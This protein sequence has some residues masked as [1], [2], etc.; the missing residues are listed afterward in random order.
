MKNI[1]LNLINHLFIVNFIYYGHMLLVSLF[2]I[3]SNNL[4]AIEFVLAIILYITLS[5]LFL[6]YD[7]DLISRILTLLIVPLLSLIFFLTPLLIF[8][9]GINTLNVDPIWTPFLVFNGFALPL[10]EVMGITNSFLCIVFLIIPPVSSLVGLE[11]KHF[12]KNNSE[13]EDA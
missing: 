4:P 3:S 5:Y 13:V 2:N 6:S 10:V 7:E 12:R 1:F 11:L 9:V 8:K